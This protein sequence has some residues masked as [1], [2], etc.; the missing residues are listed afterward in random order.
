LWLAG[1]AGCSTDIA[2]APTVGGELKPT[3]LASLQLA[4]GGPACVRRGDRIGWE[5]T[6]GGSPCARSEVRLRGTWTVGADTFDWS[7]STRALPLDAMQ[8]AY[9]PSVRFFADGWDKVGDAARGSSAVAMFSG[10]VEL[11]AEATWGCAVQPQPIEMALQPTRQRIVVRFG[12]EFDSALKRFGLAARALAV[13]QRTIELA[14]QAFS[15]FGV[16]VSDAEQ[17]TPDHA[18]EFMFVDVIDK[19]PNGLGLLGSDNSPGKDVGNLRMNEQLAGLNMRTRQRGRAAFGGVFVGELFAFSRKL[20]PTSPASDQAFDATFGPFA[21]ELGG[22]AVSAGDDASI[23]VHA[24]A[25]LIADTLVHECG[26]ALGMAAG[27]DAYHHDGDHKGWRMDAGKHRPFS[28]R[29]RLGAEAVWGPLD[30]AY[31]AKILPLK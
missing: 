20:N 23:A 7:T 12:G 25:S 24:L 17:G 30:A 3:D 4:C 9:L 6:A 31:L 13:Q 18:V 2:P 22:T 11:A 29:A 10:Q 28:E 26:H 16:T 5:V 14:Q 27:T 15:G 21:A 19:D 1:L 8:R